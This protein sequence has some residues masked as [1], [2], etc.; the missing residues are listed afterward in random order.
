[1]GGTLDAPEV[2]LAGNS[3][4]EFAT[5]YAKSLYGGKLKGILDEQL[6][7]DAGQAIGD[8][9]EGILGGDRRRSSEDLPNSAEMW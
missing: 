8:V 4:V 1:V 7:Q 5:G 2:Q 6:G 3:G 9:L